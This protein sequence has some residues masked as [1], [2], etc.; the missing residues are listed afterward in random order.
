MDEPLDPYGLGE[1]RRWVQ[2]FHNAN[3]CRCQR[4][5]SQPTSRA[6]VALS[7][8]PATPPSWDGCQGHPAAWAGRSSGNW[9][10]QKLRFWTET[11]GWNCLRHGLT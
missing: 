2:S 4:F 6:E 7:A 5:A 3:R 1:I 9:G 10:K 11:A 8:R